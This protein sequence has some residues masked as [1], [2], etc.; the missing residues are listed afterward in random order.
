[1][2][3]L[4]G[5]PGGEGSRAARAGAAA[6][7][8]VAPS[9]EAPTPCRLELLR[10]VDLALT[11]GGGLELSLSRALQVLLPSVCQQGLLSIAEPDGSTWVVPVFVEAEL[12]RLALDIHRRYPPKPSVHP[13]EVTARSGVAHFGDVT[14]EH[15]ASMAHDPEHLAL[16]RRFGATELLVLPL[17]HHGRPLG[18]LALSTDHGKRFSSEDRVL[19]ELVATRIAVHLGTACGRQPAPAVDD[20][21]AHRDVLRQASDD[22]RVNEALLVGIVS[23]DLRDPL[24]VVTMGASLLLAQ[25]LTEAQRKLANRIQTAGRKS[26]RLIADLLDFTA[27]RGS[28]I[29]ISPEPRDLHDLVAQAVEDLHT[30]WPERSIVHERVGEA[31]S[32]IDQARFEQIA[33]NLIGNALQHSPATTAVTIETRGESDAVFFSVQNHGKPISPEA[34]AQ[35]FTPLRRG[36]DAGRR[37]GSIGLGLFIVQHLVERHGGTIAVRSSEAEGT[38]FTVR[39]PRSSR[40]SSPVTPAE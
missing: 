7:A 37:R 31:K 28:G 5:V 21:A 10:Q 2:T 3:P 24:G 6:A 30:T 33:A 13:A 16:L 8:V 15:M 36:E 14:E 34:A 9:L 12:G 26:A 20:D 17:R 35:L 39:L 1:M 11:E 19:A 18:V 27:A 22:A 38:R 29:L 23:H 4:D 25:D 32:H 40:P